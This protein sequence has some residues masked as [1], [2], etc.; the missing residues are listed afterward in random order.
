MVVSHTTGTW[1]LWLKS[2]I[3]R[4]SPAYLFSVVNKIMEQKYF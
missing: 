4:L 1:R 3:Q 2:H